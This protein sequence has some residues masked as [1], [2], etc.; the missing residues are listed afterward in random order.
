MKNG[1][2]TLP[3]LHSKVKKKQI[4]G[5]TDHMWSISLAPRDY[6][7]CVCSIFTHKW[8]GSTVWSHIR[9]AFLE[10]FS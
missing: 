8:K 6:S 9:K 10:A 2:R 1:E 4:F 3:L 7:C 5:A